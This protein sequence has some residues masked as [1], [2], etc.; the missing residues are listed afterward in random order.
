MPH[1]LDLELC[2]MAYRY[3]RALLIDLYLHTKFHSNQ[4]IF[5]DGGE[6]SRPA[7]LSLRVELKRSWGCLK[8][9]EKSLFVFLPRQWPSFLKQCY[10]AP[11]PLLPD[12]FAAFGYRKQGWKK[13]RFLKK[14]FRFFRFLCARSGHKIA[15][16]KDIKNSRLDIDKSIE[17][18]TSLKY[19]WTRYDSNCW[20]LTSELLICDW[21]NYYYFWKQKEPKNLKNLDRRGF[22]GF[23]KPKNLGF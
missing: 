21:E 6:T 8:V 9:I 16:Q 4:K 1:D 22:L 15:T 13:P 11:L 19:D 5:V 18:T 23:W 20:V 14:F 7:L 10:E 3:R 17:G 2:H 12:T